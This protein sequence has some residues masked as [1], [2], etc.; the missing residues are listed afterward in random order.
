MLYTTKYIGTTTAASACP[1]NKKKAK[2]CKLASGTLAVTS[3]KPNSQNSLERN[4]KRKRKQTNIQQ[5]PKRQKP[6][7]LF[8]DARTQ[9]AYKREEKESETCQHTR[10]SST[11]L[12]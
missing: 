1:N 7:C 9:Q 10:Q 4:L 2:R 5:M 6:F 3:S 12:E 8:V 11:L